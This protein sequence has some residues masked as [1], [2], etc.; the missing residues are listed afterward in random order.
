L[1]FSNRKRSVS[2]IIKKQKF[3]TELTAG[4]RVHAVRAVALEPIVADKCPA[5][6]VSVFD[7]ASVALGEVLVEV[8]KQKPSLHEPLIICPRRPLVC[9][10]RYHRN[11]AVPRQRH[12]T[13]V[14]PVLL[15]K[16]G[17]RAIVTAQGRPRTWQLR[18]P[19]VAAVEEK[20]FHVALGVNIERP[21]DGGGVDEVADVASAIQRQVGVGDSESIV[22]VE[23]GLHLVRPD[24]VLEVRLG[25]VTCNLEALV[26]ALR[27][28]RACEPE[29]VGNGQVPAPRRRA[30]RRRGRSACSGGGAGSGKEQ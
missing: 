23:D 20:Q 27:R 3:G 7:G 15:R 11:V 2:L 24:R 19:Q 13:V 22:G 5:L 18:C 26:A 4:R 1:Y 28:M 17:E 9:Q 30:W 16:P 6:A 8:I 12:R 21:E 25:L 10:H 14:G 29:R